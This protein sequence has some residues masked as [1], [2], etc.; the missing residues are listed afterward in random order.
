MLQMTVAIAILGVTQ[1]HGQHGKHGNPEDLEA[2]IARMEEPGRAEWQKPD[3]VVRALGLQRGQVACDIGAGPGYFALRIARAV[4]ED[5]G[6]YAVDV[7]PRILEALRKRLQP[8]G[9]R[10]V[11]PVLALSDDS[12]LPPRAC[13]LILIV[14][15]Y[16]HFPDGPAYLRRLGR[17]LKPGGRIVN[18]DFHKRELPVGPA[19][20]HKLTRE[21]FLQ[22]AAAAGFALVG[23]HSFLPYQYFLVLQ[24]K[25]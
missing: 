11:T 21:E 10:N 13:D 19:P 1:M 22:Q 12:L 14:D 4:G 3:E 16:H 8:T 25:P 15:T 20:D 24:P 7:E 18:I 6:V 2:Y 9:L 23:E 17:A 5:G